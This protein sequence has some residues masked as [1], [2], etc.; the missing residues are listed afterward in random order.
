[1]IHESKMN[2]LGPGRGG[3]PRRS[4]KGVTTVR[5]E[6]SQ[7]DHVGTG[8]RNMEKEKR[9]R[10]KEGKK[11]GKRREKEGKRRRT[12]RGVSLEGCALKNNVTTHEPHT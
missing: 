11:K 4:G 1:M 6:M 9:I 7:L 8:V 3:P 5:L 12:L 2:I 10:E